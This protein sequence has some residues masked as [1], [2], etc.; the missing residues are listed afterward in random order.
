[1]SRIKAVKM[2]W[3][4]CPGDM[5]GEKLKENIIFGDRAGSELLAEGAKP[6]AAARDSG[7]MTSI[8]SSSFEQFVLCETATL[9]KRPFIQPYTT[10][11]HDVGSGKERCQGSWQGRIEITRPAQAR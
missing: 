2:T 10:H 8:E 9:P 6:A 4:S 7:A 1:M 11:S 3:M 5:L